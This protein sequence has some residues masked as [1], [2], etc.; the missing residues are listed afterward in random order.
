[1]ASTFDVPP[2]NEA[3]VAVESDERAKV[4]DDAVLGQQMAVV[5]ETEERDVAGEQHDT[6][7]RALYVTTQELKRRGFTINQIRLQVGRH[8]STIARLFGADIYPNRAPRRRG[9]K[10]AMRFDAY[11]RQRWDEGCHNAKHLFREIKAQ[12]YG[13]SSV[14]IRRY[15][16]LWR[17][18]VPD[19]FKTPLPKTPSPRAVVWL[20]LKPT[21]RLSDEE[22][23]L[24]AGITTLSPTIKR[25]C[26]LVQEFR[27]IVRE[28][29]SESLTSWINSAAESGMVEFENFVTNLRRDEA[30]VRAGL[31]HKWSNGQ[32]EGQVNRLKYIKRQMF[33]RANFDLLKARVLHVN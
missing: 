14:T 8:H 26:E 21:P 3:V 19:V 2:Q 5:S 1:M 29:A 22:Q 27:R 16:H 4:N 28:R 18:P 20:L 10:Q 30:A 7:Q 6:E 13:G 25:G 9:R 23:K 17:E 12:G 31:T 24:I 15:V 33:G 32:T 11:L